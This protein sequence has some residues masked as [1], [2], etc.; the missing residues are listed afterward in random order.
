M[1]E[2]NAK[3]VV[4]EKSRSFGFEWKLTPE[5][6][7]EGEARDLVRKIQEKR[8]EAGVAFDSQITVYAPTWPKKFEDLIKRETL[9]KNL[10]KGE[11]IRVGKTETGGK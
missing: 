2:L 1:A 9:A 8:K 6:K 11:T 7:T 3:K 10:I 5:L 4:Y